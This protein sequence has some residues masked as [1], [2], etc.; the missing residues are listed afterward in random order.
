MVQ[1]HIFDQ[2]SSQDQQT[3][4]RYF[5]G[6]RLPPLYSDTI[7]KRV[8]NAD[9]HPDRLNFLLQNIAGDDTIDVRSSASNEAFR[10][11]TGSKG[12]VSDI[13][14][15]LRDGRLS[16]LEMQRAT[17]NF[18]FTRVE[19]Y[20][21][22]MLL[23]QYS[24]SKGQAKSSVSYTNVKE[25][26]LVVLMVKSPKVFR[27]YDKKC[28]RY[29]HRF[30]TMASDSGLSYPSRAKMVYVQ[31]DKCLA[32]FK[33]GRNAE[34]EEGRPDRLQKW[35]A[36]IADVNDDSTIEAA[37]DD[38]TLTGI[39]TEIRNMAQDKE[40]QNMLTQEMFD[41]MDRESFREECKEEGMKEGMKEGMEKG[42]QKGENKLADLIGRLL[43]AGRIEDV[44]RA[45]SDPV[46]RRK[47]YEEFGIDK[48]TADK[49]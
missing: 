10:M 17:Q 37:A 14:S 41:L 18:I 38:E 25:V 36:M 20:A 29:I 40:V 26:L 7:A 32:Q 21:S 49:P 35:L 39:R 13:P 23:L 9:V 12:M 1:S 44:K 16:D 43:S 22:S 19:L 46:Y 4:L 8:F 11:S 24:A 27:D 2:L 3:L 15:W 47:L 30:T 42:M 34:A 45:S 5:D 31:L 28:D 48:S 33:A 6:T